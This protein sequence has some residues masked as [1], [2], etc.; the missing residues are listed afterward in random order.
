MNEFMTKEQLDKL[1]PQELIKYINTRN[2]IKVA[3]FLFHA[4]D[5]REDVD[6]TEEQINDLWRNMIVD[7]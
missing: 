1:T 5:L 3:G 4:D 7:M 6:G 2:D